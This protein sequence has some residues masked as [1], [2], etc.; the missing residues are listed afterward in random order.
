MSR[1]KSLQQNNESEENKIKTC[2][3][4]NQTY[5]FLEVSTGELILI[6]INNRIIKT[7]LNEVYDNER[8]C[9]D[10]RFDYTEDHPVT[11]KWKINKSLFLTNEKHTFFLNIPMSEFGVV[12]SDIVE[13]NVLNND[14]E[15][16][17][18]KL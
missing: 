1:K 14:L 10:C 8:W 16:I 9:L 15:K 4:L 17:L 13:L 6:S 18:V 5:K 11:S 7:V 2:L 12:S 3:Y